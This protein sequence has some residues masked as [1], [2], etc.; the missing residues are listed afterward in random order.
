MS[1]TSALPPSPP[2]PPPQIQL[3]RTGSDGKS[4]SS[5]FSGG[6]V[7]VPRWMIGMQGLLI[8]VIATASFALGYFLGLG[9]AKSVDEPVI[10]PCVISGRVFYETSGGTTF[11]D[12]GALVL[13]VPEDQRPAADEKLAHR[14]LLPRSDTRAAGASDGGGVAG[15][16][17]SEAQEVQQRLR[18]LGGG[19]ARADVDG[20]YRIS[21]SRG[22]RYFLFVLSSHGTRSGQDEP[23]RADLA[24]LGRYVALASELI[25]DRRYRWTQQSIKQDT[26]L[27]VTLRP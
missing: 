15:P 7:R 9:R 6:G 21:L 25:A 8:P 4:N 14:A 10:G 24:Q 18:T 1:T 19:L 11:P 17:D 23:N 12:A 22:G 27:D 3:Q 26:V 2:P 20:N 13:L 5:Q 16:S